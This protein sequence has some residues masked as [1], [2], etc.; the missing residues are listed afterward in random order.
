MM[1]YEFFLTHSLEKVF[2]DKRPSAW[3]QEPTLEGFQNEVVSFQLV[4]TAAGGGRGM[5]MQQ[6]QISVNGAPARLRRV[7]LVPSDYP[8]Y[9]LYD[10][11]YLTT[12]PGLFPDPLIPFDGLVTPICR[13]L[14]S[15]WIDVDL[16]DLS[17]GTHSI[18]I[19]AEALESIPL[20]SGGNYTNPGAS[21]Y[22]WS[23]VLTLEV[24]PHLLPPQKLIHTQ[25][26]HADCLADY[27][28]VE[29]WSEAHW[30][31]VENFIRFA[32]RE[33]GM[34]M[35]LTP[36]FTQPL[37]TAVGR[38]R[39]TV[40]LVDIKKEGDRYTF[41]FDK[42]KRWC[43]LCLQ[44][45]IS[46][47]EIAHF[48]TQWGANATPKIMVETEDGIRQLFGWHV[49]AVSDEYRQF[50]KCLIPE[51]IKFLTGLGYTKDTLFFHVSD[52]PGEAHL[53]NYM[54]A[55]RQVEDL[56]E[57][58]T[59]IDAL[60]SLEFY[61]QGIV[62][63]PIPSNDHIQSFIDHKVENLWVYY[64]CSQCVDVPNRFYAMPSARNRIMG[65]LMYLYRIKGF[66]HWGFNFYNSA[67]SARHI[68]PYQVTHADY[69]FPSGDP[70]LVYPG[71]DG[72][73]VSSIRNQVQ[74]EAFYDL[75]ALELLEEYAGRDAVEALIL[76]D[77][78]A[79]PTFC[80]YPSG[81]Q[82]LLRL[83]KKVNREIMKYVKG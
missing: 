79:K 55:K 6:F 8:C 5:P 9:G 27:Y 17:A 42:L 30:Q 78:D 54:A 44:Y 39:T 83:R 10:V 4:Y 51:L 15:V 12:S 66:L 3:T 18:T 31:A 58:Y 2:P 59:I 81:D 48:F 75:R 69:A 20:P 77:A 32:G 50:L 28:Q 49:P 24:Y 36:V 65:V 80:S 46:N 63:H 16:K 35:L 71:R 23:Q 19:Q 52:E 67:Y 11:N 1:Q 74:M 38:E 76:E 57:G 61:K 34:N 41:R 29:V 45:G 82:Y 53:K 60:S 62:R 7:D 26:F 37:D 72:Q 64:C 22:N 70:Y 43:E 73:P 56:L 21:S 14:R 40:Q 13:Q 25:W 68:D 47:L 33:C